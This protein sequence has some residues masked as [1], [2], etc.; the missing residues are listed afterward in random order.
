[1]AELTVNLRAIVTI[2]ERA[3]VRMFADSAVF[4]SL[5]LVD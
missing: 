2:V 4:L 1:M 5:P 3:G